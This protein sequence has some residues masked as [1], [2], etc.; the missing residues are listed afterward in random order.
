MGPNPVLRKLGFSDRDRLVILHADDIGMCEATVSAFADLTDFGLLSSA[1]VM[2]PCPWFLAAAACCRERTVDV[3]V[4]LT[5]TSEWAAYRW[6]PL[7]TRDPASGL[8]DSQGYFYRSQAEAQEHTR[9]ETLQVEMQA[10][11]ER[12]IAEGIRPTH[13]DTHMGVVGHPNLIATY[14]SFC[15][16]HRLP[17]MV[18][19]MDVASWMQAGLDRAT[20]EM[21]AAQMEALEAQ[22]MP[23]LDHLRMVP[24]DTPD[25]RLERIQA[26]LEDLEPGV[27]HFIIHPAKDT[28]ELRAI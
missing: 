6:G 23:M 13:M 28:P 17:P 8:L 4:H 10:Q 2:A 22:G 21:A 9:P 15:L 24:L 7:S 18:F 14:L 20:A 19:R 16:A 12:V 3:G 5:L 25:N 11:Y 1:A 27:T 26:M